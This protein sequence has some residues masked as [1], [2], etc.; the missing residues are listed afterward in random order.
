MKKEMEMITSQ[1]EVE[2]WGE[3]EVLSPLQNILIG[4]WVKLG[5]NFHRVPISCRS[6]KEAK[7]WCDKLNR[8]VNRNK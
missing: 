2:F 7:N 6:I 8:A 4:K 5:D 1:D 3:Y